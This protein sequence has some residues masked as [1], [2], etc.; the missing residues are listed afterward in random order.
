MFEKA[1]QAM[2]KL[3]NQFCNEFNVDYTETLTETKSRFASNNP[4]DV[5]EIADMILSIYDVIEYYNSGATLEQFINW[6]WSDLDNYENKR[7]RL[8]FKNYYNLIKNNFKNVNR[9]SI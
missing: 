5:F 9:D 6:Y 7:Q 2:Y 4:V 8:N 1:K 3:I